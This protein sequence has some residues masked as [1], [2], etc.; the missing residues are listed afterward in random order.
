M[1]H[2]SDTSVVNKGW[3]NQWLLPGVGRLQLLLNWLK[4][5]VYTEFV[6]VDGHAAGAAADHSNFTADLNPNV[7]QD[8][9]SY[10]KV[11]TTV[12]NPGDASS[13]YLRRD[14]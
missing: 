7:H 12:N 3:N 6:T 2:F 13:G 1:N 4:K 5:S 11:E 9:G 10:F 14:L 8:L